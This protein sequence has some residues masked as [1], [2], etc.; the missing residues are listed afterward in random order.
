MESTSSCGCGESSEQAAA[1]GKSRAR[2]A[3]ARVMRFGDRDGGGGCGTLDWV[4]LRDGDEAVAVATLGPGNVGP[5]YKNIEKGRSDVYSFGVV[6][7]EVLCARPAIK[8]ELPEEQVSLRDWALSCQKKGVLNEIVDPHLQGKVTP[9]CLR[10]F[11]ETAEQCV[12][13]RSMDRPSMGDVLQNLQVALQLQ[14][15]TMDTTSSVTAVSLPNNLVASEN[16]ST[17]STM[18]IAGQGIVFSNVAH[19]EGR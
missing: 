7:Y 9:E 13:D 11:A 8:T 3:A 12:A 14:Q 15:S 10:V 6:L 4:L 18:S 17:D 5:I 16:I 19:T 1:V 2:W